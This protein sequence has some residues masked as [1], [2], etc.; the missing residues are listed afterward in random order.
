MS[1]DKAL[2]VM[3]ISAYFPPANLPG[4]HRVLRFVRHLREDGWGVSVVTMDPG[5]FDAGV[6]R[7][8]TLLARIADGV[9]V[10]RTKAFRGLERIIGV[11]DRMRGWRKPAAPESP[12]VGT[13]PA[14]APRSRLR[15]LIAWVIDIAQFPDPDVGWSCYAT[16]CGQ[17]MLRDR[18]VDVILST[19]PPHTSHVVAAGLARRF[20]L[21]WVADFR[22]PMAR[23]PYYWNRKDKRLK[24]ALWEWLERRIV[25]RADAVVL[26]TNRMLR[27]FQAAYGER[28][29]PKLHCV[30]NGFD[31]DL[32]RRYDGIQ[33]PAGECLTVTHAG[34]LYG[35][36][37]PTGLLTALSR[38]MSR[39]RIPGDGIRLKLIGSNTAEADLAAKVREL[40]LE[41]VVQLQAPLPHGEC[42]SVMAA[43]HVLLVIQPEATVQVPAKMYE[44]MAL[45]RPILALA[46]EG[47][48]GD[49]IEAGDIGMRVPPTDVQAIEDA[50]C[51]FYD[52]RHALS[53]RY[54][55]RAGY[56]EGF[57]G[58]ALT[59][60]LEA[61]LA[62]AVQERGR[63]FAA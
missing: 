33:P 24:K 28:V 1:T 8:D 37:D 42:L 47:A 49:L 36:R 9:E 12:S 30:T 62:G 52:N 5:F 27:E 19:A 51:N 15:R 32:F 26:N 41:S 55:R 22:D 60:Q 17:A 48:V 25:F 14:V 39:G 7:D 16:R 34:S 18:P 44:Y 45:R 59:R 50:L 63:R 4:V 23:L 61:V 29:S 13:A 46:P 2:S 6:V 35:A 43:S 3:I 56:R 38:A 54:Y 21:P 40:R 58:Q 10:R 20:N 57:E 11:R 31:S 53:A